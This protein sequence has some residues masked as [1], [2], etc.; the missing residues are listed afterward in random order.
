MQYHVVEHQGQVLL[1]EIQ[2]SLLPEE[3]KYHIFLF[4]SRV[5]GQKS[6]EHLDT[7]IIK[8]FSNESHCKF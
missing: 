1:E 5:K 3:H 4:R 2:T 7:Q 8:S 6:M